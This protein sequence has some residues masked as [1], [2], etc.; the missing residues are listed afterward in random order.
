MLISFTALLKLK[1]SPTSGR[2]PRPLCFAASS[3]ILR[4]RSSF[5]AMVFSSGREMHREVITGTIFE[6]PSSTDFCIMYSSLS[7]FG[8]A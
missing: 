3:A 2:R 7:N 6:T 4:S 8:S 1:S 5:F